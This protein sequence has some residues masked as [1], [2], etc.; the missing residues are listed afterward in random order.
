VVR[1]K[2]L[3]LISGGLDSAVAA[4]VVLQQ[5]IGLE[6]LNFVSPFCQCRKGC[7]D[8]AKLAEELGIKLHIVPLF[9]E[10]LE[11]VKNPKHGYGSNLNPCIDCRILMFKKAKAFMEKIGASFLVTGEVLGQRPMSQRMEALRLIEKESDLEGLVLRPLSAK[12]LP[13]TR[14]EKEGWIDREL[15]L[16]IKGRSRKKQYELA[17]TYRISSFS[18]PSG[19]CLLTDPGFSK[20]LRDLLKHC[21]DPT[22]NDIELL[23]L[24][25]HFRLSFEAKLVVGRNRE[26]NEKIRKLCR[27]GDLLF[28]VPS[29]SCPVSIA[30]GSMSEEDILTSARIE[31]RYSDAP[32]DGSVEVKCSTFDGKVV[33]LNVRPASEKELLALMIC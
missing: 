2:A 13:P 22:L 12:F 10:Y 24:G 23:K 29:F 15:L 1:T 20:R 16:S 19:G 4:K 17:K 27:S 18:C 30:R 32:K 7:G 8:L 6:A 31:A 9:E 25:R 5:G 26:E 33:T 28:E 14:A 3:L 21:S 11:I